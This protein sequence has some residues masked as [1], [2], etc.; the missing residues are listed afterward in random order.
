MLNYS[1]LRDIQRKEMGSSAIVKLPEDFYQQVSEL[2]AQKKED[3]VST[4][5]LLAIKEYENIRKIVRSVA[6]KRE[7]KITLMAVRGGSE[8]AGL[9]GEE[10]DLLKGLSTIIKKSRDSVKSVWET[11]EKAEAESRRIKITKDVERYRGLD[12]TVYGPFKEGE[13]QSLPAPEAE[14]LLKAGMAEPL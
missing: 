14:W 3:A 12:N 1:E 2:L 4:Q 13:E 5:S 6:A 8:G 10:K 7:E 9:T 11:D